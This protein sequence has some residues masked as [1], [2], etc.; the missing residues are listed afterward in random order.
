MGGKSQSTSQT[1]NQAQSQTTPYA[2]ASQDIQGILGGLSTSLGTA[3]GTPFTQGAFNQLYTNAQQGNPYANAVGSATAGQLGGAQNYGNATGILGNAYSDMQRQLSPYT[4]GNAMDPSSNPALAQQLA[5]VNAD[6]S[7]QVNPMFAAAGRLGSPDNYQAMARGITQGSTGILQNAAQNQLG[8]IN[9]LYGA[10]AN[11]A[12]GLLGADAANASIQ[13]SGIN[14]TGAA[15]AAPNYAPMQT[16]GIA[17]AQQSMPVSN[18]AQIAGILGP[19]AGMFGQQNSSGTSSTQGTQTMSPA[20]QAMGW[21]N[22]FANLGNMSKTGGN[23][24]SFPF[25]G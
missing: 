23:A 3:Q 13:N 1:Q 24:G 10:G 11:T 6:V 16:L 25:Q 21:I 9:S 4:S 7:G 19:I 15:L 22:A 8:A 2:P 18:M 14:N 5:T 20:Q 17:N 12:G